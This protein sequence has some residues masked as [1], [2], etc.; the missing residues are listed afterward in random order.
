M[1]I[2]K[3]PNINGIDIITDEEQLVLDNSENT[4]LNSIKLGT[5]Q[6]AN[7]LLQV[8]QQ[9]FLSLD[10]ATI[11]INQSIANDDGDTTWILV[12]VISDTIN[13]NFTYFVYNNFINEHVPVIGS[14]LLS[15]ID[16][17]KIQILKNY[18]LDKLEIIDKLPQKPQQPNVI[19]MTTI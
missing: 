15:Y 2:Y 6:D 9:K 12:D 4:L 18:N 19:G 13:N 14:E 3:I 1:T 11:Y 7:D 17:L 10:I 5:E 16:T 8:N